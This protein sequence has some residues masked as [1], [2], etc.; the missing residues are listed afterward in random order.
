[1]SE[2]AD[3]T[4]IDASLFLGMQA[5]DDGVRRSCKAFFVQHFDGEV[6][7]SLEQVGLCDDVIWRHPRMAQ[8][9]YYPFMDLLQSVMRIR[10]LPYEA[11]DVDESQALSLEVPVLDRLM[12]GQVRARRGVLHSARHAV[13]RG[14]GVPVVA[15][16]VETPAEPAFPEALEGLYRTSLELRLS[17]SELRICPDH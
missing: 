11:G 14:H 2:T 16:A 4:F 5:K 10:R 9:A 8:D 1:M 12:L 3:A 6:F 15:P 7:M 17:Q 13:L